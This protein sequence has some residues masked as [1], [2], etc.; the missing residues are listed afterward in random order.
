MSNYKN[1]AIGGLIF[2]LPFTPGIFYLFFALLGASIPDLDHE[3]NIYKVRAMLVGG[4]VLSVFL[5]FVDGLNISALLLVGLAVI[6]YISKHRGFTHTL[7]GI[8]ILSYV[9]LLM[10]MGFIPVFMRLSLNLGIT[11]PSVVYVFVTMAIVG[12]F[13]VSR[14]YY[15]LYLLVLLIYLALYPVDYLSINWMA[16]FSMFLLGALSHI[17]LDLLTPAG[18]SFFVP[19]TEVKFHSTMAWILIMLWIVVSVYVLC[20]YGS[21]INNFTPIFT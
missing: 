3:N 5:F 13:I 11:I 14:R 19:F 21:F 2:A 15:V 6:F 12:Y 7:L 16:V 10:V 20:N 18:V 17:V 1:H 9:F 4:V 8:C